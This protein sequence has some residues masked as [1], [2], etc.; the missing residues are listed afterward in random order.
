MDKTPINLALFQKKFPKIDFNTLELKPQTEL[1]FCKCTQP[2]N[3]YE[4][5]VDVRYLENDSRYI[6]PEDK[7]RYQKEFEEIQKK[8]KQ[9]LI[10]FYTIER[11]IE[12]EMNMDFEE[13]DEYY[14]D[15]CEEEDEQNES[16]E[17]YVDEYEFRSSKK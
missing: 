17:E 4:P 5:S 8:K 2:S 14:Q 1:Q 7:E 3:N 6:T 11:P 15:G 9:A 10:N 13:P 12:V 16:D